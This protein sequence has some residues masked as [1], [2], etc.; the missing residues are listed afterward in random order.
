MLGWIKSWFTKRLPVVYHDAEL[1]ELVTD[2]SLWNGKTVK[3]GTEICFYLAGTELAPNSELLREL[4]SLL[5]DFSDIE[6]TAKKFILAQPSANDGVP[7][8]EARIGPSDFSF[9]ALDFLWPDA[10]RSFALEFL[11]DGDIDGIWRV[12][13]EDGQPRHLCRDD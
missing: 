12:E 4:K 8:I 7:G 3:D 2:S 5:R 1:G 13:F 11:I 10:P 9:Y 6:C